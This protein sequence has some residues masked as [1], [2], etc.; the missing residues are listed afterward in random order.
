M[1]FTFCHSAKSQCCHGRD[2][3]L[4]ERLPGQ[5]VLL[6]SVRVEGTTTTINPWC[7]EAIDKKRWETDS[8]QSDDTEPRVHYYHYCVSSLLSLLATCHYLLQIWWLSRSHWVHFKIH[9][10]NSLFLIVNR[11]INYWTT[12]ELQPSHDHQ[13]PLCVC[14]S[15]EHIE[16]IRVR[17]IAKG[18]NET[19]VYHLTIKHRNQYE[20][21]GKMKECSTFW[22]PGGLSG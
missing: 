19:K 10:L 3:F 17:F 18:I 2:W 12:C 6:L 8:K 1:Y 15:V 11:F 16:N 4:K 9:L 13:P 21:S 20:L 5:Q 7:P 14:N 22:N